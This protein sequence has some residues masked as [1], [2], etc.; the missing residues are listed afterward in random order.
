MTQGDSPTSSERVARI[1]MATART[2]HVAASERQL[3]LTVVAPGLGDT[4]C[5]M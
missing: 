3:Q 5:A 1:A 4:L 2:R